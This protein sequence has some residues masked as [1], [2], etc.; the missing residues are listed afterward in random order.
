MKATIR[1]IIINPVYM[2]KVRWNF[3]KSRKRMADGI[4]LNSRPR[5]YDGDCIVVNGLHEPIVSEETFE[6]AQVILAQNPT[7]PVG[8]KSALKNPLAG[9]I[10]CGKCGRSMVM[11]KGYGKPDYIICHCPACDNVSAPY[12]F[13]EERLLTALQDWLGEYT[14]PWKIDIDGTET[15]KSSAADLL[16]KGLTKGLRTAE[17]ELA[18]LQG[19]LGTAHDLLE[20]GIYTAEQFLDRSHSLAE[21]ISAAKKDIADLSDKLNTESAC[22]RH[23]ALVIPSIEHLSDVYNELD[24]PAKKN[25][26]LKAVLAKAVYT[27]K[28]NGWRRGNAPD[29]F[30]L[31]IYPKVGKD[32]KT[33]KISV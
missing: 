20:Q 7:A 6:A 24:T 23:E 5:N 27:K 29:Q 2:G 8:Y 1:D 12:H 22:E 26:L 11:R 25:E 13:V 9:L 14:L 15:N 16:A 31:V 33:G 21:R 18:I 3:K 10:I 30:E 19:Q 4:S 28:V 17:T 32:S